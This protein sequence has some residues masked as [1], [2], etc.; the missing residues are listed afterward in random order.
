M[1]PS[2]GIRQGYSN[3]QPLANTQGLFAAGGTLQGKSV[4]AE[5]LVVTS[6]RLTLSYRSAS[7]TTYNSAMVAT[8]SQDGGYDMLRSMVAD[9]FKKQGISQQVPTGNGE[10]DINQMTPDQAAAL[11]AKDGYFGIEKTS[12]R[13]VDF[14]T[15]LAGGDTSKLE[16]IKAAVKKGFDQA[17]KAFGGQ[18][19]DISHSTYN[20]IMEKLD[21]WASGDSGNQESTIQVT[22]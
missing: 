18:L 12:S 7:V 22:S 20:A 10:A 14:A 2:T 15:R 8:G 19:P 17:M 6:D 13:I 3:P 4:T 1:I 16:T 5:S 21:T 9:I 11:V